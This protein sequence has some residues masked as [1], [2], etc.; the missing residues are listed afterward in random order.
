MSESETKIGEYVVPE[1]ALPAETEYEVLARM[2]REIAEKR[3]ALKNRLLNEFRALIIQLRHLGVFDEIP[4]NRG[5]S[6]GLTALPKG[7]WHNRKCK[8]CGQVGHGRNSSICP[9][10][11]GSR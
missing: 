9:K 7:A 6:P 5:L 3:A 1:A 8:A 2:E 11:K 4:L 10:K